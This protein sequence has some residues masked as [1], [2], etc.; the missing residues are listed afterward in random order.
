VDLTKSCIDHHPQIA[1]SRVVMGTSA[2]NAND[3]RTATADRADYEIAYADSCELVVG[4]RR[5][6]RAFSQAAG[7]E[8][9]PGRWL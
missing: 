7:I 5:I 3:P 8:T 2:G 1:L 9:E 4:P 6:E